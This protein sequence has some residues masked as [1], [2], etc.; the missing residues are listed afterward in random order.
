MNSTRITPRFAVRI[1]DLP[2]SADHPRELGLYRAVEQ[3]SA[4]TTRTS[5]NVI[6]PSVRRPLFPGLAALAAFSLLLGLPSPTA[7]QELIP[8]ARRTDWIPS[9][10]V[11]VPGG[12][13]TNRTQ[14]IDVTQSP[15]NADRTGA[16]NATPAIQAAINA[17]AAGQIV[18]L[19]AGKYRLDSTLYVGPSR[20]NIT[21]RGAGMDLTVLDARM[22]NVAI[23][24]GSSSDY[25]W[26]YP[27]QNNRVTGG[28]AKGSTV[29][30]VGDTSPFVVG[31]LVNLAI[32]DETNHARIANGSAPVVSVSGFRRSNRQ[33]TRIVNKTSSTLTIFPGIYGN[34]QSKAID[35]YWASQ[36]TDFSGIENLTIECMNGNAI[37]GIQFEQAYACWISGV[38]VYKAANYGFSIANSLNCEIRQSFADQRSTNGTNGGGILFGMSSGCLIEDNIV[39]GFFPLI[40]VNAGACGNVLAYNFCYDS[41][42][43]GLSGVAINTN[44]GPHNSFNLYEGNVASTLQSDGYFGSASDDTVF[45]NWLHGTNPGVANGAHSVVLNRF[46]RNYNLVGNVFGWPGKSDGAVSFGNPNM[47]NGQSIGTA[48]PA[49][50]DFWDDWKMSATL[51]TR[52]SDTSG[53]NHPQLRLLEHIP[54]GQHHLERRQQS[55]KLQSPVGFREYGDLLIWRHRTSP[56]RDDPRGVA[57]PERLSRERSGCRTVHPDER[58]QLRHSADETRRRSCPRG[59]TSAVPLSELQTQLVWH[60]S[61]ARVRPPESELQSRGDSRRLPVLP[62]RGTAR[63]KQLAAAQRA[64]DSLYLSSRGRT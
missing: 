45:R 6:N 14:L 42:V 31:S 17:A 7:A 57:R 41:S 15:Y 22:S 30:T 36:Q 25:N 58:Q 19:P 52:S 18:Y 26:S 63:R 9:V 38:R 33:M 64:S 50:G 46:T 47:G 2:S 10:N 1:A 55:R 3:S 56:P 16:T 53:D 4:P 20:D 24:L 59:R 62:T 35:V 44:H 48:Q 13:P 60:P 8:A 61:L 39:K 29:L 27:S 40:E 11:G 28:N 43:F 54:V 5:H 49:Q 34:H 21:I 51:T 37:F 32:E 23:T 12:I